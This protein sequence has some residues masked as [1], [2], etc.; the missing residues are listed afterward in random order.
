VS[1]QEPGSGSQP[2]W[3]QTPAGGQPHPGAQP[4]GQPYGHTPQNQPTPQNQRNPQH[5]TN[6]QN[7]PNP[8]NPWGGQPPWGSPAQQNQQNPWGG[9]PQW[10]AP[11]QP[12]WQP[13]PGS[14][15]GQPQY[16]AP[17]KPGI[18]PLRPLLFGE[19]LDGAFQTIRR[20]P[21][22]MLGSALL[23]QCVAL[24]L[25]GALIAGSFGIIS[26]LEQLESGQIDSQSEFAEVGGPILGMLAGLLGV[27]LLYALIL[28]ILGGVM[29]VPVSRA[30]LN[31]KTGFKQMW[32]LVRHRLLALAGL[33]LVLLLVLLAPTA[34]VVV[35]SVALV[36]AMGPAGILL[37]FPIGLGLVAVIFWLSIKLLVAPAALAIEELGIIDSLRR[38]W[39][40]TT[41]SWWRTFGIVLVAGLIVGVIG[42]VVQ[43]PISFAIGGISSVVSPHADTDQQMATLVVTLVITLVVSALVGALG[44]AFQTAISSLLY[45]DMRMRRDGLDVELVRMMESGS[46]PD[47]VPGRGLTASPAPG[48]WQPPSGTGFPQG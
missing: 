40:L 11:H 27:I 3:G 2:P 19:I 43:F 18:V 16:I 17:P 25:T 14:P 47:G 12:A 20:N 39:S 28:S 46:D 4:Q 45:L 8:Q 7:Q 42:Q 36:S 1:Q 9:Q 32:G 23:G 44:F 6:P 22:S 5:H 33:S 29:A 35:V 38:S 34:V 30:A 37:V 41:N 48:G 13:A 31:R 24:L 10:G 26:S 21:A 15:Y